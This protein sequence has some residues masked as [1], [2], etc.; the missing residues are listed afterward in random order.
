MTSWIKSQITKL[1]NV[2]LA[3]IAATRD[4]LVERLQSV[5]EIAFL[6]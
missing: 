1:Y 4:A 3:T 2:V 5:C 6:L